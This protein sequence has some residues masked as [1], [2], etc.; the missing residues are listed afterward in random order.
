MCYNWTTLRVTV[1]QLYKVWHIWLFCFAE[2]AWCVKIDPF[3][4]TEPYIPVRLVVRKIR[5]VFTVCQPHVCCPVKKR[6]EWWDRGVRKGGKTQS[7]QETSALPHTS[8]GDSSLNKN[9]PTPISGS[10]GGQDTSMCPDCP[11]PRTKDLCLPLP[12][13]LWWTQ[14]FKAAHGGQKEYLC[15]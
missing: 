13:F 5:Y 2:C 14:R 9:S 3:N 7:L 8:S 12:D 4:N 1:N 11:P 10:G 6:K 15:S